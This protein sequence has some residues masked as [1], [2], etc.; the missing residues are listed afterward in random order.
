MKKKTMEMLPE[1]DKNIEKLQQLVNSTAQRLVAL[2]EKW[3]S[4]R[5]PLIAKYRELKE[6]NETR[7]V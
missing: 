4:H 7:M 1:A 2:A 5:V 6:L 3:E